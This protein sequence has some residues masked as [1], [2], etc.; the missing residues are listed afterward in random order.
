MNIDKYHSKKYD[1][2]ISN[3]PYIN[4]I[5][6]RRL[7]EDV[8]LHEPKSA[9]FGGI[10]GYEGVKKVVKSSLALLRL[11]G[12]LILEIGDKQKNKSTKILRENGFYVNKICKDLSGKNRVLISTKIK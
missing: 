1:V 10:D 9:L 7:D 6:Y 8:K 11:N 2:I 12:K 5:D 3:P 4:F